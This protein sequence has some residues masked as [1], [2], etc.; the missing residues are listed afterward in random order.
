MD[1]NYEKILDRIALPLG[2]ILTISLLI[3][4]YFIIKYTGNPAK[5][6]SNANEPIVVEVAGAVVNPGVYNLTANQIIED[7]LKQAGGLTD[8]ADIALMA[9]IVNRAAL[10]QN[11]GKVYVPIRGDTS[12][13]FA[14]SNA[15]TTISGSPPATGPININTASAGGLDTLPGIGPVTAGRII[16]YR[17]KYGPFKRKEDLMKVDGIG[18]A[19]YAKL[20]ELITI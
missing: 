4:A 12:F 10:L 9:K 11:H 6:A 15:S 17:Q 20:K 8:Q 16:D 14:E 7:A 5:A 13:S 18:P 1:F 2:A 3:G 19:K